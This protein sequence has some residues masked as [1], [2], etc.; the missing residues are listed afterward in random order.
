MQNCNH[1][2]ALIATCMQCRSNSQQTCHCGEE[3]FGVCTCIRHRQNLHLSPMLCYRHFLNNGGC[4]SFHSSFI[5]FHYFVLDCQTLV[6]VVLLQRLPQN[7]PPQ[8]GHSSVTVAGHR[9]VVCLPYNYLQLIS[10]LM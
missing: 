6:P 9:F 8:R 7:R 4:S 10:Y 5:S 2:A 1:P 3:V